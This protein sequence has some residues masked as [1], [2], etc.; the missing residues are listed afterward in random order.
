M[1]DAEYCTFAFA[2]FPLFPLAF[3]SWLGG[4][5]LN[6]RGAR[7]LCFVLGSNLFCTLPLGFGSYLVLAEV[8]WAAA[9]ANSVWWLVRRQLARGLVIPSNP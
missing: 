5:C 8:H 3:C 1:L 2:V 9:N 6:L 7:E 4:K